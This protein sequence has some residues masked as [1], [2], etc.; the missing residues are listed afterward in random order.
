MGHFLPVLG[1]TDR[2]RDIVPIDLPLGRAPF[3]KSEKIE[4]FENSAKF[5]RLWGKIFQGFSPRAGICCRT[6][7]CLVTEQNRAGL[8]ST[9]SL[10]DGAERGPIEKFAPPHAQ[11]CGLTPN[12]KILFYGDPH[13]VQILKFS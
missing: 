2:S 4:I 6:A 8:H 13:P 9:V 11:I 3:Q 10:P 1:A 7:H 12:F 5:G